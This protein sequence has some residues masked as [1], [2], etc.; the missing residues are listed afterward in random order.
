MVCRTRVKGER[1]LL[2]SFFL[3][4]RVP[5]VVFL[6]SKSITKWFHLFFDVLTDQF[7]YLLLPSDRHY[8]PL[9]GLL[10]SLV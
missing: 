10:F 3:G 8:Y 1:K 7:K 9:L 5:G 6:P 2:R 4:F